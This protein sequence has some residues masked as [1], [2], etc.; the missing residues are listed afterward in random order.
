MPAC[1]DAPSHPWDLWQVDRLWTP[2]PLR[3]LI[4]GENPLNITSPYF[5]EPPA[6]PTNVRVRVRTI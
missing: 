1:C 2:K 5:Y 4:V 3:W 6:D